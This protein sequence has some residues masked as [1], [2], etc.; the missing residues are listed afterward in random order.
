MTDTMPTKG[1]ATVAFPIIY[2]D[3]DHTYV[4][5][6]NLIQ[7][8][9]PEGY[10]L[11]KKDQ[12]VPDLEDH[13]VLLR[14]L[15]SIANSEAAYASG[16]FNR[17]SG[18]FVV[19][20]DSEVIF[21]NSRSFREL[22]SSLSKRKSLNWASHSSVPND[23]KLNVQN[24]TEEQLLEAVAEMRLRNRPH[25]RMPEPPEGTKFRLVREAEASQEGLPPDF[26]LDFE[27]LSNK[28]DEAKSLKMAE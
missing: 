5:A 28:M 1:D 4:P 22:T 2:Y 11:V 14:S 18:D 24:F 9:L 3:R 19:L 17:S 23:K 26:R 6:N 10:E 13:K 27:F 8:L 12:T 20:D 15:V 7:A 16:L 25:M 21:D